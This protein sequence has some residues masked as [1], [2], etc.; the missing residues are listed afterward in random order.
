[1]DDNRLLFE[2]KIKEISK[3]ETVLLIARRA[4]EINEIR[5]NLERRHN[6]RLIEKEKPTLVAL[7]ELVNGK[8]SYQMQK[9]G[10][11][12]KQEPPVRG[13]KKTI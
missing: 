8:L 12:K 5:I 4:R 13:M 7:K 10:E 9:P 3:Y 2:A 1:M 6:T 11:K